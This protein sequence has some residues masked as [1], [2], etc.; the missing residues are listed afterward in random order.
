MRPGVYVTES[1][2]A[3]PVAATAP[4]SSAGAL[5]APL[6]SGPTTPTYV[7]SWYAFVSLFGNLNANYEATFAANSFFKSGGRELYVTRVVKT[8]AEF[9]GVTLLAADATSQWI[10]FV[11]KSEGTYGNYLRIRITKN[12]ANY[13]D[14]EVLKD[15]GLVGDA[16]D[17]VLE[18]FYDLDLAT[19]GNQ[20]IINVFTLRS[21]YV[22]ASWGTNT[23]N[24]VVPTSFSVLA[25]S[26]GSDGTTGA[27]YDYASALNMLATV[28][29]TLVIFSPAQTVST[30]VSALIAFA[31]AHNSFVVLDTPQDYDVADTLEYVSDI[32]VT[33]YAAVY[34]PHLWVADTT[35][36]S[37][38]AIRM[39]GPSGA[40]AGMYLSTDA[41][42]GV[43]KAPAGLQATLPGV[44]ALARSL[45]TAELDS[46]NNDVSPVNAIRVVAGTGPVVMGARTLDQ[47]KSTRYV[48]IR[49]TLLYLD[50]ELKSRLE[51]A[52]F[53]NND[54]A[55]WGRM[56][57]TLDVFLDGFWGSGGLRG[58]T[59]QQAYYIKID[60]E[61]NTAT[62]IANGIVNVEVGIALQYPAEFI[63][64]KLTQQTQP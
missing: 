19:Y 1:V 22:N 29:R 38:D 59:K 52:L 27:S 31:E 18:T 56:R 6:P 24:S 20:E 46:M 21:Q 47:S 2:I 51:F 15:G 16:D 49:R 25:L 48:N 32:G 61:N 62:D 57:T 58:A 28:D 39:I 63:K 33:T 3:T 8:D 55:L 53:Q 12:T 26:T 50:R 30:V 7:T 40:V 36:R 60:R 35:S 64:I 9:A 23:M 42:T 44:V 11:S 13:Y 17:S 5:V 4:S 43:F 41:T 10:T 45:T 37:R 54:A 34:Y 14:I